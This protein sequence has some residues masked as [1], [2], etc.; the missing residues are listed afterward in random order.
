MHSA[1]DGGDL[2]KDY[3]PD[4]PEVYSWSFNRVH[5]TRHL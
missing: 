2:S 4:Y 1:G 3:C 5:I